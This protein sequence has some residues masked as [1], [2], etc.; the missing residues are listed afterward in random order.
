MG[1]GR[2]DMPAYAERLINHSFDAV[3]AATWLYLDASRGYQ[4]VRDEHI[5]TG[6]SRHHIL[7]IAY[8]QVRAMTPTQTQVSLSISEFKLRTNRTADAAR[9]DED[10]L[11]DFFFSLI[12]W[13]STQHQPESAPAAVQQKERGKPG[14][15]S[16]EASKYATEQFEQGKTPP[17]I[18]EVYRFLRQKADLKLS[19]EQI[20][21]HLASAYRNWKNRK[22]KKTSNDLK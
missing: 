10:H 14:R 1:K 18:R 8:I 20:D 22:D 19:I 12:K 6:L 5:A 17:D 15:K 2:H 9:A 7:D 11:R 16:S 3:E 4:E 21:E 13:I